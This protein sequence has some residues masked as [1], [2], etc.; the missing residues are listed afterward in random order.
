MK[1]A[2]DEIEGQLLVSSWQIC[3]H[4]TMV[5]ALLVAC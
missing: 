2:V 5:V 4:A 3:E 1:C